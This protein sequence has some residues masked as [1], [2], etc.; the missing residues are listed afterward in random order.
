MATTWSTPS[1]RTARASRTEE[2]TPPENATP[3][4]AAPMSREPTAWAAAESSPVRGWSTTLVM[5]VT[6]TVLAAG[7]HSVIVAAACDSG[8]GE[9]ALGDL[10]QAR[11]VEGGRVFDGRGEAGE[12]VHVLGGDAVADRDRGDVHCATTT[13]RCMVATRRSALVPGN[14][15]QPQV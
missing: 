4:G 12:S 7:H 9:A 13:T 14:A 1:A 15:A 11:L 6:P 10:D 8:A 5:P 3:S 2:S